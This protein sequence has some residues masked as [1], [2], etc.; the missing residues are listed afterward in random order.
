MQRDGPDLVLLDVG[1]PAVNGL[2]ALQH[3]RREYPGVAVVMVT[4]TRD[5]TLAQTSLDMGASDYVCKPFDLKPVDRLTTSILA[6]VKP[7]ALAGYF[8]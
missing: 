3:I 8:D 2:V 7:F 6:T 1:F 4:G 5:E